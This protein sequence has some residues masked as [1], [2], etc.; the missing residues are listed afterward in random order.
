MLKEQVRRLTEELA[1]ANETIDFLS[2]LTNQNPNDLKANYEANVDGGG[3]TSNLPAIRSSRDGRP[4]SAG[5]AVTEKRGRREG[6][7]NRVR[8]SSRNSRESSMIEHR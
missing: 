4:D 6:S 8:E 1:K 5:S 2:K 7:M 3:R